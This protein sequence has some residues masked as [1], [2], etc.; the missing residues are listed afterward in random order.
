MEVFIIGWEKELLT[1]T[2]LIIKKKAMRENMFGGRPMVSRR[3]D[4]K[5]EEKG[6]TPK[7]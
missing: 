3:F 4:K 7:K 5:P 6:A 1:G 2:R